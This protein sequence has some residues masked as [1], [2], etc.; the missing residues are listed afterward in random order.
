ML[1]NTLQLIVALYALSSK[2]IAIKDLRFTISG[3]LP[4]AP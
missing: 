3:L 4:F 1:D 2:P